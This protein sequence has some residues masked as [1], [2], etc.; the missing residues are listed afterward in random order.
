GRSFSAYVSDRPEEAEMFTIVGVLP[1]RYWHV[2]PYTQIFA[3]LR[4]PTYPY[5]ARLRDHVPPEDAE[6]RIT[7]L[8]RSGIATAPEWHVRLS[9][10]QAEYSASVRP[11]LQAL[12]LAAGIV[13]I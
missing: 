11:T 2:N 6:R 7:Q 13:L 8:V 10:L 5:I 12:S 4:T 1:A 3:P 9:P